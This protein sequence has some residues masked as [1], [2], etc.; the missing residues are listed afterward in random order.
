MIRFENVN[1]GY[2]EALLKVKF[3]ELTRGHAYALI[4]ENGSG[5]S[6]FLKTISGQISPFEGRLLINDL[7]SNGIVNKERSRLISFVPTQTAVISNISVFD[8]VGLGR[9]PYLNA[10]GRFSKKDIEIIE[11]AMSQLNISHL[12]QK[13]LNELSDGERQL[14]AIASAISQETPIILLDEPT[15]Y[16]DYRNKLLV[17]EKVKDLAKTQNKCI[18]FST[19]DLDMVSENLETVV[20]ARGKNKQLE[21]LLGKISK[22][23]LIEVAFNFV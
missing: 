15:S 7:D 8:F 6:T 23:K 16:L 1:I 11:L 2:H 9:T 3:T 5:K 19:H 17:L 14:S 13:M 22:E 4:G 18:L 12:R 10:L 21:L 20:C